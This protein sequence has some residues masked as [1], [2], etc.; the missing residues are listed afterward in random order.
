MDTERILQTVVENQLHLTNDLNTL[1]GL[2]QRIT[3]H[4][5]DLTALIEIVDETIRGRKKQE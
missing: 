2:V 1:L 3:Q 5:S 4:Q